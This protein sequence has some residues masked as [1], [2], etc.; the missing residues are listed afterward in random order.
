MLILSF[1]W[2]Y[3]I[4][5]LNSGR[6]RLW[7]LLVFIHV[8]RAEHTSADQLFTS[9]LSEARCA[10]ACAVMFR[11][12]LRSSNIVLCRQGIGARACN[13]IQPR[14]PARTGKSHYDFKKSLKRSEEDDVFV[15]L[16]PREDLSYSSS[17][18][19]ALPSD[20]GLPRSISVHAR[21]VCVRCTCF[22]GTDD[23]ENVV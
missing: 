1:A 19:N 21:S 5:Q 22:L 9:I 13:A 6:V 11:R 10:S 3:H 18:W 17:Q 8:G 16:D 2:V 4:A 20:L 23:G 12:V 15:S 7:W 14:Q